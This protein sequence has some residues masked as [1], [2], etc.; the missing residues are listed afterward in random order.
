MLSFGTALST[1]PDHQA[2]IGE[3]LPAALDTLD[4]PAHLV[5][6]FFSMDHADAAEG[7]ALGLSERSG[8]A[9]IIGC[10][11]Q[12][13]I[14][15]GREVERGP[16]LVVWAAHLPGVSVETFHLAVHDLNGEAMAVAGWPPLDPGRQPG[17]V[18]LPDP[19]SFPT[20]AF[21]DRLDEERPGLTVLGGMVSGAFQ[22][23]RHRLLSGLEVHESGAVGAALVGPVELRT[24]VSQGCRPIGRPFVVTKGEANLVEELG[25]KAAVDRLR[26]TL[27][28]L[29]PR[30][31]ALLRLGGLQVGQVIN[32]HKAEFERGDFL[33][34]QLAGADT[35]TGAIAVGDTVE[36]G[37]TMQFHLRDADAADEELALMLAPVASWD[38]KGALLF[39]C[40]GRGSRFFGVPDHDAAM[41]QDATGSVPTA[42]FFAQGELGPVGGRNFLHGYTASLAV[43]CE[44]SVP[45]AALPALAEDEQEPA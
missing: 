16:A 36:L 19:F 27:E 45:V 14:A 22:P 43:F 9:E 28:D 10:T 44:P 34:R 39:S 13:I 32:E 30:E 15:G 11:G 17:V 41:V 7:I 5:A 2:A 20:E 26:E 6:C 23:G 12:G 3:A 42:G 25:G 37:Q 29:E 31:Q 1:A 4:G 21:L 38:P 40:N 24:V 8:T 18:L 35:A 33:I